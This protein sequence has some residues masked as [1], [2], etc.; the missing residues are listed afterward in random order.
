MERAELIDALETL[1]R[2]ASDHR[3]AVSAAV[4]GLE[5]LAPPGPVSELLRALVMQANTLDLAV[6]TASNVLLAHQD[7][8]AGVRERLE[9][10]ELE[11][12]GEQGL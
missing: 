9:S 3:L 10:L 5:D 12:Y 8:V 2:R 6:V 7:E 4:V 1:R 11:V